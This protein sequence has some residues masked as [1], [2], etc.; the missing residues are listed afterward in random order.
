MIELPKNVSHYGAFNI[1]WDNKNI[2]YELKNTLTN[3]KHHLVYQRSKVEQEIM[4]RMF[5][6][7]LERR[8]Q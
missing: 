5:P 3:Q 6:E 4:D 8:L 7:G 2:V 1:Y